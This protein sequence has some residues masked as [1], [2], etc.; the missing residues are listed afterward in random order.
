MPQQILH[1]GLD[2]ASSHRAIG[3]REHPNYGPLDDAIAKPTLR[4]L[5]RTRPRPELDSIVR[6]AQ[7][8]KEPW[9]GV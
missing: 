9:R 2:V 6:Q 5:A 7:N 8:G 3:A 4:L 1:A